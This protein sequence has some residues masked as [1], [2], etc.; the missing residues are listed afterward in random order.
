VRTLPLI[1]SGERDALFRERAAAYDWPGTRPPV[2]L[3]G[4]PVV[5]VT[6][7]DAL[8]YCRWLTEELGRRFRLP[9]EAEWERAARGGLEG[10]RYPWGDSIDASLAHFHAGL[11]SNRVP[12]TKPTGTYQPN[13]FGLYDM[14]GNVWEWVADWYAPDYYASGAAEDPKGPASGTLRVVRGGAWLNDDPEMLRCSYRHAVPPDTYSY[15]IGF[16]IVGVP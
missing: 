16:R 8:A 15:T 9:T 10:R 1:A 12:G 14:T 2:G 11:T 7:E 13:G 5:L 3:G 6:V 4:H